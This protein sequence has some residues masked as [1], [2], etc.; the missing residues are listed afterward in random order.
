MSKVRIV[1]DTN[2]LISQALK[3]DSNLA[4]LVSKSIQSCAILTSQSTYDEL[5]NVFGRFVRKGFVTVE[6]MAQFL[7]A[8][9]MNSHWVPIL[10]KIEACRDPKDDKF[11]ELAVNGAA[12]YIVTGDKDLLV[13]NPFRGTEILTASLFYEV[14]LVPT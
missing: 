7:A 14:L 11:L 8:Y 5:V 2:I 12:N 6:E 3:P 13:L 4:N 1:F 10:E 9:K